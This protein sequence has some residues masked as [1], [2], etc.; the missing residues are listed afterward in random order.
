MLQPAKSA[1]Q[2]TRTMQ[3]A[4]KWAGSDRCVNV[5][6]SQAV[7]SANDLFLSAM[8]YSMDELQ[9]RHHGMFVD[10]VHR[11][12]SDYREFLGQTQSRRVP[13]CGMQTNQQ[14]WQGSVDSGFLQSDSRSPR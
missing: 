5:G 2:I 9:G 4:A 11:S 8:G 10:E 7:I 1:R 14:R 12:S 6:K 3:Q 13:V